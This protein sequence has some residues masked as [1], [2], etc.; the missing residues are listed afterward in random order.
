MAL[1]MVD[2][3]GI[4]GMYPKKGGRSG[5]LIIFCFFFV[6]FFFLI[7]NTFICHQRSNPTSGIN[8]SLKFSK[9]PQHLQIPLNLS[10]FLYALSVLIRP[11]ERRVSPN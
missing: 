5:N 11:K 6:F 9:L 8:V 1:G 7:Q 10:F 3:Y 2:V 4:F